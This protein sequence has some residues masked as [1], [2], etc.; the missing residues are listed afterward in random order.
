MNEFQE[1]TISIWG[2]T[3]S[4]GSQTLQVLDAFPDRFRVDVLTT[5]TRTQ[6]LLPAVR[7]WRPRVVVATSDDA[8]AGWQ[9]PFEKLGAVCLSGREGLLETAGRGEE[10]LVVNG[11]VGAVGLEATLRALQA[12]SSIAL[13]NKEVL[14]MAGGLVMREAR[15]R[16]LAILPVDSEHSALF[17]VLL[18][19]DP[20]RVRRLLLTASGGPF[21][22]WKAAEMETITPA[23]ALAHPNWS[24]GRKVTIDSATLMNKG[25]EVIEA[26]WLFDQPAEKIEVVIHPQSVIHSMV[27]FVDG[28][29]K[30]QLSRP[31]M[32]LPILCALAYPDRWPGEYGRMDFSQPHTLELLP[33]DRDRFPAL[34]LAYEA[35]SRGGTAPA[36]LNAADEVAVQRFLEGE[37]GFRDIPRLLSEA[38]AKHPFR[39]DPTLEEILA[40]DRETRRLADTI[41]P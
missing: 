14:V 16:S 28:S 9:E 7:R 38:L 3:G 23:Q 33:P 2:A 1:K 8:A 41:N 27:E 40:V 36:A 34:D 20:A 17:Q 29:V 4:I 12:G 10:D 15:R 37:I 35:L 19:E 32:R 31:D 26:R 24:M 30:A 6:E 13:A 39:A 21:L 18:G 5:H 11:L 25:L 22:S